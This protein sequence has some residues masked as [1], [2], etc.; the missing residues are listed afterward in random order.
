MTSTIPWDS[1]LIRRKIWTYPPHVVLGPTLFDIP[2]EELFFFVIQTYNTTLL[3]LLLGKP[4]FHPAYLLRS[5]RH[6]RGRR[7]SYQYAGQVAIALAI[8]WAGSVLREGGR[9]TYMA[10][11]LAWAGPFLLLLWSLAHQFI[12]HLP[13]SNTVL[14]IALPTLYL[15]VVDTLALQRGTWVIESGTKL[16]IQLWHGLDLEEAIFFLA[17]NALIVFGLVAFDQAVA[18]L[19]AFPAQF[20]RAPSLPSPALLV[21]ALLSDPSPSQGS[22]IYG[23]Q[24]ALEKLR[25]KSRSFY[26]ASA[27][28]QGRL[29]IDLLLL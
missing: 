7:R 19:H 25:R 10:L 23:F 9:A 12:V 8:V 4:T 21:R 2:A 28:F 15:W 6:Q 26:L 20:P 16:G 29:R 24:Q 17:T 18:I 11:I 13:W 5:S 14:P 3:Y 1:Y 22:R 27:F